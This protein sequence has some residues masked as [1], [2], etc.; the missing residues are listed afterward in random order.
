MRSTRTILAILLIVLALPLSGV[1][2]RAASTN[3]LRHEAFV[4]YD[5]GRWQE[6]IA[7]LDVVLEKHPKDIEA[8]TKRGNGYMRLDRPTKALADFDRL[9]AIR[10]HLP[11]G[12]TNRAVALVMLG[13]YD[14]AESEFNRSLALWESP[15]NRFGM[16]FNAQKR[17]QLAAD[18]ATVHAGL[19][20]VYHRTGRDQEAVLQYDQA[21]AIFNEDTNTYIGRGDSYR[22]LGDSDRALADF[23]EAIRLAPGNARAFASRGRLF[24][25]LKDVDRALADYDQAIAADPRY[26]FAYSLRGGLRSRLGRNEEALADFEVVGRLLPGDAESH[27][28]RGGVL[29]RMGRCQDALAELDKAIAIDPKQSKAY[30]NRGAAYNSLSRYDEAVADLDRAIQLDPKNAGAHSNA[31]LA[32]FMIGQYDR[33][34]EDLSEAVRLA[35]KNAVARFNRGNVFA[36]LGLREQ[37]MA[38]YRIAGDLDPKL[39]SAY[40]GS[41]TL[42]QEMARNAMAIRNE[43]PI[44]HPS[45]D[46]DVDVYLERGRAKQAQGEWSGAIAD[47]DRAVA[48]D[49]RRADVYIAR[50]W[51]RLCADVDGAEIDAHAYLN[52]K[53]WGDPASAY[54]ALLG[55]LGSR[56]AGREPEAYK[57][58]EDALAKLP[59]RDDWPRPALLYL[60][61]D[62]SDRD[63]VARAGND[64][65]KAEAHT[66]LALDLIRKERPDDARVHLEW[67]VSHAVDRSIAADVARAALSRLPR[68]DQVARKP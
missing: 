22:A 46:R 60:N 8:L 21:L 48:A 1:A 56:R 23:S 42:Y 67:V 12:H 28:D 4:L 44:P 50:G 68:A 35:P 51:S 27:K 57:F 64:V 66:I 34:I 9:V 15:D 36:K 59:S 39:V 20:Q 3:E 33:S 26:A 32:Y 43:T 52:L 11:E 17:N 49:P 29:V 24:E 14:D 38:D 65:Q 58:L 18:R 61:G 40:G 54:M 2:A 13:R 53:G 41:E 37:A 19:A 55:A 47:Y 25:D 16:S 10:P 5:Q 62:L 30:Q 63:L 31:G 6:S 7:R 45:R